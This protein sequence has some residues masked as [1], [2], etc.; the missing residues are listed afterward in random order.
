MTPAKGP[1]PTATMNSRPSTR[2]GTERSRFI[3][4]RIRLQPQT[5][6]MFTGADQA[7][8]NGQEHRQARAPERD[9]H[10]QPH[11]GDVELPVGEVRTQ[12]LATE[13]LHVFRIGEQHRQPADLHRAEADGQEGDHPAPDQ[14]VGSPLGQGAA[15]AARGTPAIFGSIRVIRRPD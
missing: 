2:S 5:G 7:E 15:G 3:A 9:L 10:R 13:L 6:E 8:W 12:Q 4:R 11:L 14:D 1:R